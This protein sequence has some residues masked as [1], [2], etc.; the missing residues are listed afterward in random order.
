MGGGGWFSSCSLE[1]LANERASG[2][3]IFFVDKVIIFCESVVGWEWG[4]SQNYGTRLQRS[5]SGNRTD[6]ASIRGLGES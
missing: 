6:S 5:G 3:F 4:L 1:V 2:V